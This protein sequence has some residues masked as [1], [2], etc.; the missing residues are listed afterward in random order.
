MC[1]FFMRVASTCEHMRQRLF[2]T[3]G[4]LRC[5]S[6]KGATRRGLFFFWGKGNLKGRPVPP[7]WWYEYT[8]RR[9]FPAWIP[10]K[11]MAQASDMRNA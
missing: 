1:V 10:N 11:C 9:F 7:V 4:T 3:D 2:C 5:P 8:V 6:D